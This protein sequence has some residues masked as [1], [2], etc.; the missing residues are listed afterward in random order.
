MAQF[1]PDA[2]NFLLDNEDARRSYATVPDAPPGAFAI[3]GINSAAY[4]LEFADINFIA[5]SARGPAVA[6]FYQNAFW[7]PL[8]AG[9]LDSQD[10]ANRV[11]DQAVNGGL[12]TGA[13][14]LQRAA[15]TCGC[16]LVTDGHIGPATLEAVNALDP[17]RIIAAYRELRCT[18][19]RAIV[20]AKPEDQKYL[21]QWL[22]R[23]E[24]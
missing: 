22:A 9:G 20:E 5:Q 10:L 12:N 13:V 3:S 17:E 14:M 19:Y 16:T 4:P 11:L 15:N 6:S 2:L 8:Q 24:K 1:Q 7:N 23:A 18:H 21:A